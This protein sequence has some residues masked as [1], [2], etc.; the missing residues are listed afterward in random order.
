MSRPLRIEYDHAFYHI[1]ARG[2]EKKPIFQ[3]KDDK[4]KFFYYLGIVN[5]RYR[6][7]LY[8]YVLMDNHYHLLMETPQGNLSRVMRDLNGHY[9][10]YFNRRH[11]RVGHLFQGRLRPY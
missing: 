6:I 11:K 8:A 10:I 5:K 2:N 9:T 7:K 1:T 3:D 4:M